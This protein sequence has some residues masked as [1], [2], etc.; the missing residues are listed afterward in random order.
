MTHVQPIGDE[1]LRGLLDGLIDGVENISDTDDLI[2]SGL[3]SLGM[4]RIAS[5]LRGQGH[6]VNFAGL[7][8]NPTL[9]AWKVLL[10]SGIEEAAP[11]DAPSADRPDET[12]DDSFP[13]AT[14]QHAYWV[15]R[16]GEQS[17]GG[18]AAHLYAEFD[19]AG[20]DVERLRGAVADLVQRHLML[21]ARFGENGRQTVGA[22]AHPHVFTVHDL[23]A[24]GNVDAELE[25]LRH[26]K[27]HQLLDV[28]DGHVFDVAL[29]LLPAGRTRLHVD[30]DMLAA[31]AM[32]YRT[33][34][35]DLATFYAGEGS[36]LAPIEYQYRD[37]LADKVQVTAAEREREQA[38]W[39]EH[40]NELPDPPQLPLV[41]EAQ[42]ADPHLTTRRNYH[43]SAHQRA[44]L[45]RAAARHRLTPAVVLAAVFADVI[46][47]WSAT[48][49]FLLNLPLFNREPL[50]AD[51]DALVGDFSSSVMVPVDTAGT[52]TFVEFATGVQES[53]HSSALHSAYPGLDVIR[54]LGRFRGESVLAPVVYTSGLDLGELFDESV[55]RQFGEPGWIVSQG[56]QVALDAQVVELG[57]GLLVNWDV[58]EHAFAPGVIDAMFD[59]YRAA[60]DRLLADNADWDVALEHSPLQRQLT[61]RAEANF[62]PVQRSRKLL[63]QRFFEFAATTPD[64]VALAYADGDVEEFVTYSE[65]AEKALRTSAA[66]RARGVG[67]GATV[68]IQIPKGP[69]QLVAVIGVL[70]AGATYLPIGMDQPVARRREMER[71]AGVDVAIVAGPATRTEDDRSTALPLADAV[72]HDLDG[73]APHTGD[74][75]DPAYI[76]FTSGSTG[77][78]KGV[79]V[80][81]GAVM[82]TL[83]RCRDAFGL[84]AGDRSIALSALEFD[85]SIEDTFGLFDVG[86]SVVMIDEDTRRDG[87]RISRLIERFGVTQLYCVP[88]ILD[89]VLSAADGSDRLRTVR[90]VVVGGDRVS[91]DL[92]RRVFAGC[93]DDVTFAGLGGCTETAIHHTISIVPR[94]IPDYPAVPFGRPLGGMGVRVV[95]PDSGLDC[96][97]WV[98]GEL[99]VAGTSVAD[100]YLADPERTAQ[101]FVDYQGHRWYRTGDLVRFRGDGEVE[102]LG[103]IDKQVKLRGYRIEPGEVSAAL[104]KATGVADAAVVINSRRGAAR[105]C[106]LVVPTNGDA[107]PDALRASVRSA[108]TELLPSY[109]I[110]DV[111]EIAEA[112]PLT[113]NGKVDDTAILELTDRAAGDEYVE[114]ATVVERALALIVAENLGLERVGRTDDFFFLGGDSVR[115]TTA[116]AAI[117]ESLDTQE[118]SVGDLFLGRTIAGL[119]E[120]MIARSTDPGRL[121]A[122]AEIYCDI[123]E[124]TDDEVADMLT[125]TTEGR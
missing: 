122:V 56:P 80:S 106:A 89:M 95:A 78:P 87:Q 22:Q 108:L 124:L 70:A 57:G 110:P 120:R 90:T 15:G 69:D 54:D 92:P 24:H 102:F 98:A 65:L 18:V 11:V 29:T 42:R 111:I 14:M 101:R 114:P 121:D 76:L 115:A 71:I 97:D 61:R 31:D 32:S 5:F 85:L 73:L 51:V 60:L 66:L 25:R 59:A 13:L 83:E 104:R 48:P 43:V 35:K 1:K 81:H 2:E 117:M 8:A 3:S 82:N 37:Y 58:R 49:R 53:L 107:D 41:P 64:A 74:D 84:V 67:P 123:V 19:G 26:A 44:A 91:V 50:H 12:D 52:G 16:R 119:A 62:V 4:M 99:W 38:W 6:A 75:T 77:T 79:V 100:G 125:Q 55:L 34:M 47:R 112:I 39:R 36:T 40:L 23:R 20:V 93:A 27:S 45:A 103:R 88:G 113:G 9:R 30:V 68:A 10:G 28:A 118:I 116:V 17:M 105:L 21:R 46:G 63:H 96:P 7:A 33:L 86:A 94:D 72:A 109:M